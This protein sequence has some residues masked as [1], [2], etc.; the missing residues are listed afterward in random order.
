M[1]VAQCS[2][3]TAR[4]PLGGRPRSVDGDSRALRDTPGG[5]EY[6]LECGKR[7]RSVR[8]GKRSEATRSGTWH[9]EGCDAWH[10]AEARAA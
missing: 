5:S 7:C 9:A 8:D 2:K 1:H 4:A 6:N 3:R 10:R